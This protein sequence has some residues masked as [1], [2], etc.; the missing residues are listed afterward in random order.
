MSV[1]IL[2]PAKVNLSL[3]VTGKRA[4]GY[5]LLDSLV[6]FAHLGDVIEILPSSECT[7]EITGEFAQALHNEPLSDN[8]IM[9]AARLL[10]KE[11]GITQ[12]AHIRLNKKI[13]V[14]AGLGG[15]SADAAATIIGLKQFWNIDCN[16]DFM[17]HV[18]LKLGSDVPACLASSTLWMRGV[19]ERLSKCDGNAQLWAVLVNPRLPLLTK[20]VFGQFKDNYKAAAQGDAG[21]TSFEE[22]LELLTG[23][24]NSLEEPAIELMP[25]IGEILSGLLKTKG[26]ALARMSGS[27]ASCFGLYA[28][29]HEAT[30]AAADIQASTPSWWVAATEMGYDRS[31]DGQA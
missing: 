3:H 20:E 15:G 31:R 25:V 17:Q 24:E 13:P 12:G 11:A 23:L 7:L 30:A 28:S 19:G 9:R 4:D 10:Q 26:C 22:L 27:G 21:F 2:A 14:G 1:E 6:M 16:A 29:Q 8:L 5:H 18:A